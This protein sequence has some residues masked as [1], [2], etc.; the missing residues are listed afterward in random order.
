ML[1][2][3]EMAKSVHS[4]DLPD[5]FFDL[6]I[7]DAKK[8]LKDLKRQRLDLENG[9]L[10]TSAMR[11]LEDS[12]KQLRL[13]NQYKKSIIRVQFPDRTVLQGT[14]LP[15]ETINNV[16]EF[17]REYLEDKQCEFHLCK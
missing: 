3:C 10:A 8:L 14:F 4:E 1:F 6:T 15:A 12:K 2:S 5:D 13:L 7:D 16:M 11:R 17:V 9:K